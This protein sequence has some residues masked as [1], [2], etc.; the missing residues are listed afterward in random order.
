MV[1]ATKGVKSVENGGGQGLSVGI[2]RLGMGIRG[3]NGGNGTEGIRGGSVGNGTYGIRG[4]NV[5]NGDNGT[6]GI[7]GGSVDVGIGRDD[8]T[9]GVPID[10]L[11]GGTGSHEG[12]RVVDVKSA[13][14]GKCNRRRA[15]VATGYKSL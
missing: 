2:W 3:D 14:P 12:I 5:V 8:G 10:G 4:S 6:G 1:P 13:M 15:I 9:P 7:R 11:T